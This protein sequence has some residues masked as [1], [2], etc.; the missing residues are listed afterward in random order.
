MWILNCRG[1]WALFIMLL[2]QTALAGEQYTIVEKD[3]KKGLI[4]EDGNVVIPA[5]YEN[6]GWSQGSDLVVNDLTGYQQSGKWGLLNIKNEKISDPVYEELFPANE[7]VIIRAQSFYGADSRKYGL[8][9][10]KGKPVTGLIYDLLIPTQGKIVAGL[11]NRNVIK[12]G[13]LSEDG[14]VEVPIRYLSVK[15]INK[16]LFAV[17]E[18]LYDYFLVDEVGDPVRTEPYDSVSATYYG[19]STIY[20]N[21]MV[22]LINSSGSVVVEP[23]YKSIKV[24]TKGDINA[25]P[26][27]RWKLLDAQ[28]RLRAEYK[29]DEVLPFEKGVYKAKIGTAEGL[30]NINGQFISGIAPIH[31][32]DLQDSLIAYRK[33]TKYG[34]MSLAGNTVIPPICDSVYLDLPAVMLQTR[35][36]GQTSWFLANVFG[37]KLSDDYYDKIVPLNDKLYKVKSGKFWGL[38][39]RNGQTVLQCKYDRIH[40]AFEG[41]IKVDF[42]GENGVLDAS[43]K[44]VILP[45][46]EQIDLL[47][48]DRYLV[49]SPYGS[50]VKSF[51][52]GTVFTTKYFLYP[53]GDL[54][55]EKNLDLK[56]GLV[57]SKGH[58]LTTSIYDS[59]SH[60]QQD[61]LYF[62]FKDGATTFVTKGGKILN[63]LD[64]RFQEVKSM[65]D[66]FI[67]VKI[68]GKYGYVDPNG[69]LRIANQY[70]NVGHF[71]NGI[72]SVKVIG[73]WGF[74]NKIEQFVIQPRYDTT[75]NFENHLCIVVDEDKYGL[76]RDDGDIV[77]KPEFDHLER[78]PSGAFISELNGKKGLINKNGKSLILPRFETIQNLNNGWVIVSRKDQYG[79]MSVSGLSVIPMMY[80]SL[81]HD[82]FN[83][84]YLVKELPSWQKITLSEN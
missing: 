16:Y 9:N 37:K 51:D 30:I 63:R 35:E 47:P 2:T 36:G 70:E 82:P 27:S 71:K 58:H 19:Y 46:K 11:R 17:T 5:E 55:L 80:D 31:M 6:I 28:N 74:V 15:A 75:F 84:L 34:V 83:D 42:Y 72:G 25:L 24:D 7:Q 64:D 81:I 77:I 20:Q 40:E 10:Y 69:D 12:Y 44:W 67:G 32:T 18:N 43:G 78:L 61:S 76:V 54:F 8:I 1:S 39:N 50:E 3:Q 22:G 53:H 73:N 48:G 38:I 41:R 59:I 52:G 26:F 14:E 4:N 56:Y 33:N 57:S 65:S 21:G 13:V 62:A 68:D 60:L 45:Q 66:D 23:T 79:L 29:F 49:R